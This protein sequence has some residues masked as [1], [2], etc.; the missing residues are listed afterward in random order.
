V[1]TYTPGGAS[2]ITQPTD[3]PGDTTPEKPSNTIKYI[4]YAAGAIAG[5]A[6][7]VAFIMFI[8]RRL[9]KKRENEALGDVFDRNSFV[10]DSVAIPDHG[11]NDHPSDRGRPRPP[12]MIAR[13]IG[14]TGG[15]NT[16][17]A[18]GYDGG[19]GGAAVPPMP[20]NGGYYGNNGGYNGNNGG[21]NGNGYDQYGAGHGAG[22]G[23]NGE[24]DHQY[25]QYGHYAPPQQG[26]AAYQD[27]PMHSPM[28]P[29]ADHGAHSAQ[30]LNHQVGSEYP[31]MPPAAVSSPTDSGRT[32]TRQP[33][34]GA[35]GDYH[36][37]AE[38]GR[39]TSV[40]PYQAAQYAEISKR[41]DDPNPNGGQAYHKPG[42]QRQP[43]LDDAYGGI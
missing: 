31:A 19:Y 24:Y 17:F 15:N 37:V 30:Y 41:L 38:L 11:D 33:S 36:N 10:R 27:S 7:L 5:F 39:G 2:I 32:L 34:S 13:H 28:D 1:N 40:T 25:D 43:T 6:L 14:A 12:T 22:H 8:M 4:G 20:D 21:Y 23:Y 9:N 16:P 35:P 3:L 18:G 29:Y 26:Y 42:Q